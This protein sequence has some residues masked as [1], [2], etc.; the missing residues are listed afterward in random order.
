MQVPVP[1]MA[2]DEDPRAG[3]RAPYGLTDDDIEL[4]DAADRHRHVELVRHAC[5]IDRLGVAFS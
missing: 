3:I 4:A 1:D 5:G 2:I